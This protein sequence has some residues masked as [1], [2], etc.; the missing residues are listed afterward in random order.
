MSSSSQWELTWRQRPVEEARN[1]NPAFCGELIARTVG[2]YHMARAEPLNIAIVFLVVPLTLH[3]QTRDIL[4]RRA[5]TAFAGWIADHNAHLAE[6]PG[7]VHQLRPVS[8]EALLFSLRNEVIAVEEG[9]LVPGAKKIART[10]RPSPTTD[11]VSEARSA[12][13]LIGRW[14]GSQGMDASILQG[15]GVAP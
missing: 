10:S 12:A 8:R 1:F 11:D 5:S 9:G 2:E 15:F 3:R 4:P 14:F 6:F 13:A 7:R